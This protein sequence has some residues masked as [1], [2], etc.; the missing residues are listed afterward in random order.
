MHTHPTVCG[1][2]L[3][4]MEEQRDNDAGH[5]PQERAAD[6]DDSEGGEPQAEQSGVPVQGQRNLEHP[7]GYKTIR[8]FYS[9]YQSDTLNTHLGEQN[10]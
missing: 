9:L 8:I 4:E 10:I 1:S 6:S 2:G 7:R 3:L 5:K